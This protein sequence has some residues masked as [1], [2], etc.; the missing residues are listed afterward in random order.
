MSFANRERAQNAEKKNNKLCTIITNKGY[1][2]WTDR[3]YQVCGKWQ[4]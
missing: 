3:E 1:C 2:I 4:L